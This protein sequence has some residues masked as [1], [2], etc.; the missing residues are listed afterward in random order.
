ME[1]EIK[2]V[3]SYVVGAVVDLTY[4]R[5][6]NEYAIETLPYIAHRLDLA[7]H[8][9]DK[10]T[11]QVIVFQKNIQEK[12]EEK[13]LES[14]MGR[15]FP[16]FHCPLGDPGMEVVDELKRYEQYAYTDSPTDKSF[17]FDP[18]TVQTLQGVESDIGKIEEV[19]FFGFLTGRDVTGAAIQT[20]AN[21]Q[22]A[23]IYVHARGTADEEPALHAA[24]LDL[25]ERNYIFIAA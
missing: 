20:R 14:S 1:T 15:R 2:V 12:T 22:E 10:T 8:N 5:L 6:R 7:A 23:E 25:L 17:V 9:M 24:A 18:V 11:Q 19:H 16:H 21:F 13:Y 3:V 4:G